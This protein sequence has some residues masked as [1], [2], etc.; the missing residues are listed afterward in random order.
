MRHIQARG[1]S[2]LCP[3]YREVSEQHI[4]KFLRDIQSLSQAED[5]GVSMWETQL[6][7]TYSDCALDCERTEVL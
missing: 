2:K 7:F 3:S 1:R 6:Q 5:T 4:N